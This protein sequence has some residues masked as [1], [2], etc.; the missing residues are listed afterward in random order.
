MDVKFYL[1]VFSAES[2]AENLDKSIRQVEVYLCIQKIKE[3]EA[4]IQLASIRS[5]GTALVLWEGKL[6][7]GGKSI[8]KLI[9]YWFEFVSAL[10][11]QFYPLDYR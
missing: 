8:R 7:Q 11:R 6:Q 3:D 4:N 9:S 10:R 5:S 2:N 1:P